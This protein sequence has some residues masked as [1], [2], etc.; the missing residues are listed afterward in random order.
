MK[1]ASEMYE[2]LSSM[3]ERET[4][5]SDAAEVQGI[6]CGMLAGGML[7]ESQEWLDS[8]ADFI[9]QGKPLPDN[10][11]QQAQLLQGL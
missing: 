2:V 6:Q 5:S 7:L 10:I 3:M 1:A 11:K 9:N 4:I 8:L